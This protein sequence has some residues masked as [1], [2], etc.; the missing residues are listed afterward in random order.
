MMD[1]SCLSGGVPSERC[2]RPKTHPLGD[3]SLQAT[4]KKGDD[5]RGEKP[6]AESLQAL[7]KR[8]G[9]GTIT[10]E[11]GLRRA[12]EQGD[13]Y[14]HGKTLYVAGSH[15]ARDWLDDVTKIPFWKPLFGGSSAIHRYQM[16]QQ[17]ARETRPETVVGHSLGGAVALEMQKENPSLETRT[18]GAPV[19]DPLGQSPGERYRSRFDPVSILDRGATSTLDAPA[20]NVSGFHS[21]AA[22]ASRNTSTGDATMIPQE[23][24]VAITE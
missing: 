1:D 19:F 15:T 22:T 11:E 2:R 24:A 20:I 4:A 10:D 3:E 16:A 9:S 7:A 21:Y 5:S 8:A 14:T 23:G 18:Y 17:A 13:S 6:Q 12:Y